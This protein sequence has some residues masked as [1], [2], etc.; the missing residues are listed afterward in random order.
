KDEVMVVI[1][2]P[3][4]ALAEEVR[5]RHALTE[6]LFD[7]R[8]E[9]DSLLLYFRKPLPVAAAR[10]ATL[11]PIALELSREAPSAIYRS[12]KKEGKT[13]TGI[14][15][16]RKPVKRNRM[17]TRGWQVVAKITNSKKQTAVVYQP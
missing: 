7:A 14:R 13:A 2:V 3:I 1:R 11:P 12:Q 16:R 10:S 15:R 17:K 6:E 9:G 5:S 8:L 4:D